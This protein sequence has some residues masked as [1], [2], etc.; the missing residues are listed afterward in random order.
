MNTKDII[1]ELRTKKGLSQD[2][3]AE[4]VPAL[5][6]SSLEDVSGW[7]DCVIG[8]NGET[9]KRMQEELIRQEFLNDT[10][11]GKFGSKTQTAV[12]FFQ[13]AAGFDVDGIASPEMQA[14]LFSEDAP[15]KAGTPTAT[16][17]A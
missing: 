15:A 2:E 10:A 13:Q 1:F 7:T 8:S 14:L 17:A 16:P 9:V 4:K 5:D 12:K 11:D 6:L 3:L